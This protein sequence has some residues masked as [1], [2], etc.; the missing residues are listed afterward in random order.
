MKSDT[1]FLVALIAIIVVGAVLILTLL[2]AVVNHQRN[3]C[4]AKGGYL[5]R[6]TCIDRD[7]IIK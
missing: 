2:F 5:I 3:D 6:G 1:S 4:H 7:V